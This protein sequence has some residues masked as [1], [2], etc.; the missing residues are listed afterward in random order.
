MEC[1]YRDGSAPGNW[2]NWLLG[3]EFGLQVCIFS[4]GKLDGVMDC[5]LWDSGIIGSWSRPPDHDGSLF[6]VFGSDCG[7]S[8]LG[9]SV[10]G[11]GDSHRGSYTW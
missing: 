11:V 7:W 3:M 5:I 9:L 1:I 10:V 4:F 8:L 6:G 2:V